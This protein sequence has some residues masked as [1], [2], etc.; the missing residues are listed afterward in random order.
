M[1]VL[2][3]VFVAL[4]LLIVLAVAGI[5][6]YLQYLKPNYN[7]ELQ[8]PGLKNKVEVLY[9]DYGIPHIY[10]QNEDDLFFAFGYV[11]AQDRL[12]QMEILR[13]LADGRLS[14]V[15]GGKALKSDKLFRMLSFRKHARMTIDSL[16]RDTTLPYVRA[17]RY[18]LKGLN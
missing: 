2:K 17:A 15:F 16:Y 8:L 7:V 9:D 5:F 1:V 10:A 18:Y 3:R 12:F 11:H 13:R 4:L 6:M 14:E